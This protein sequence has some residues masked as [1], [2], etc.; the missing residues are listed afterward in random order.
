MNV[1]YTAVCAFDAQGTSQSLAVWYAKQ[2]VHWDIPPS[3]SP[4]V[5]SGAEQKSVPLKNGNTHYCCFNNMYNF[6]DPRMLVPL[7]RSVVTPPHPFPFVLPLLEL[8][9]TA[10]RARGASRRASRTLSCSLVE[11]RMGEDMG[12]RHRE[13]GEKRRRQPFPLPDKQQCIILEGN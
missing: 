13:E 1:L 6:K 11:K 5:D 8:S 2:G 9:L 12:V 3:G 7:R 4:P 10:E